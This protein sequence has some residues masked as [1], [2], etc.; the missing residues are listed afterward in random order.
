MPAQLLPGIA[1]VLSAFT[2]TLVSSG[3]GTPTTFNI[4]A[5]NV[6]SQGTSYAV[7]TI[8]LVDNSGNAANTP[9]DQYF[10]VEAGTGF[11]TPTGYIKIPAG[12][13][14]VIFN[15][16][17]LVSG[18]YILNVAPFSGPLGSLAAKQVS[19]YLQGV[20]TD[21]VNTMCNMT[22]PFMRDAIRRR[23]GIQP[24]IDNGTGLPGQEPVDIK[25]PS[26]Q[27]INQAITDTLSEISQ[28]AKLP[29]LTNV[30]LA[31]PATTSTGL[32]FIDLSGVAGCSTQNAVDY[33]KR[34]VWTSANAGT[35]EYRLWPTAIYDL[36]RLSLS[37]DLMPA[38][39]PTQYLIEGYQLGILPGSAYGGTISMYVGTGFFGFTDDTSP[40]IQFPNNL[41]TVLLDGA[42]SR[43]ALMSPTLP[44]S[45][46]MTAMYERVYLAGLGVMTSSE[47]DMNQAY[48]Q[49][50]GF[51]SYR[52]LTRRG[53]A[54][55]R[56]P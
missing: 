56:Q 23:L 17:N 53:I 1:T 15:Y 42:S 54:F 38:G 39:E 29:V 43:S 27:V 48:Q 11:V 45:Q 2:L 30:T 12:S 22:R 16:Y 18:Q 49:S 31:V 33:I 41:V 37:P 52:R 51:N 28:R 7:V 6:S 4:G 5:F 44:Q 26:N 21:P 25:M 55:R 46:T 35:P 19:A 24:P 36:D 32:Q 34:A 9:I 10:A 50:I 14:T 40:L 3:G 47:N 20:P 13:S 8:Q